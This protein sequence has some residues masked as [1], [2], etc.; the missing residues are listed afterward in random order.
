MEYFDVWMNF[1]T[2]SCFSWRH[3]CVT[4]LYSFS[5]GNAF[6]ATVTDVLRLL[7]RSDL[8]CRPHAAFSICQPLFFTSGYC[9]LTFG[10]DHVLLKINF[11]RLVKQPVV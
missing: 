3:R 10:A 8:R 5:L 6:N 4:H 2:V 9:G 7:L 1:G 11:H